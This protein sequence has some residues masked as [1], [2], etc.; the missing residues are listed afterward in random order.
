MV[1]ENVF[2]SFCA[3]GG[4][5][6]FH[7]SWRLGLLDDVVTRVGRIETLTVELVSEKIGVVLYG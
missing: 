6:V 1:R 3:V 5:G 2:V 4:N 7:V